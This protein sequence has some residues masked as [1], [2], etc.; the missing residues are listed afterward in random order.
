MIVSTLRT[1]GVFRVDADNFPKPEIITGPDIPVERECTL[2][3]TE[4][5]IDV[6]PRALIAVG[7]IILDSSVDDQVGNRINKVVGVIFELTGVESQILRRK[8]LFGLLFTSTQWFSERDLLPAGDDI[9]GERRIEEI[10]YW[11]CRRL[12]RS[13]LTDS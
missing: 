5:L 6:L 10:P 3:I 7:L 9:P 4:Y 12:G 8:K 11:S 13:T 2:A 1:R